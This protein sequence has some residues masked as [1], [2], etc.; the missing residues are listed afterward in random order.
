MSTS[1]AS[2]SSINNKTSFLSNGG[3]LLSSNDPNPIM[4]NLTVTNRLTVAGT[5]VSQNNIVVDDPLMEI[6]R[7]NQNSN[8]GGEQFSK[9]R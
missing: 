7:L 2:N 6:R 5:T 9:V 3:T 1:F 4:S 8:V